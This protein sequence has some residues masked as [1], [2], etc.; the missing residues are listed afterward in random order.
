M[1]YQSLNQSM[2]Q[3]MNQSMGQSMN[4]QSAMNPPP[5]QQGDILQ[6]ITVN[7]QDQNDNGNSNPGKTLSSIPENINEGKVSPVKTKKRVKDEEKHSAYKPR[8]R[9]S[10]D[11]QSVN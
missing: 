1:Q 4:N 5:M 11:K 6:S 9:A 7:N 8:S 2:G 3:S 10:K